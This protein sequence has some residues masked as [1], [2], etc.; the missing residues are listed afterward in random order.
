MN[1]DGDGQGDLA[2][3]GGEQRAVFVYQIESYRYWQE[4]LKRTDLTI[5]RTVRRELHDRRVA[6]RCGV[7]RRPL[8]DR[9]RAV[10]G[11]ATSRYLLSRRHSD[12]R[13]PN[14]GAADLQR[15]AG[16][17]LPRSRGRR[18]RRGRR[19]REGGRG[20]GADD[21]RRDQCA[22]LF[23]RIIRAICWSARCESRRFRRD[24]ARSFE[25]LL[26]SSTRKWK[27]R[28]RAGG[29]RA[30]GRAGISAAHGD[31]D[32]SGVRGRSLDDDAESGRSAAAGRAARASTWSCGFSPAAGAAADLSQLLALGSRLDRALS[33]QREDRAERRRREPGCG[34]MCASAMRSTSARLAAASFCKPESGRSCCSAP[35]SGRRRCWRCCTRWRRRGPRGRSCGSTRLAIGEHHP[36]AAEVRRLMLALAARPQLRLLQQAGLVGQAGRGFRRRR[37]FVA[38]GVRTGSASRATRTSTSAGRP[39]FMADM[40]DGA[41]GLWRRAGADSHRDLQRRRVDDSG[42]GRRGDARSASAR[43]ATPTPVRWCRSRAAASPRTGTRRPTRAF[44]SWPRRATFRSAGRAGPA[45]VTTARAVWFRGRWPTDR[46][47][48]T[49]RPK[50]TFSSAARSR[51]AISSSICKPNRSEERVVRQ[52]LRFTLNHQGKFAGVV[53]A[54]HRRFPIGDFLAGLYI[55]PAVG[56]MVDGMKNQSLMR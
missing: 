43:E 22:S 34:I 17:L 4:Q 48:S 26:Q 47:R 49:S 30:S 18:S 2:G 53:I 29:G 56:L 23:A 5:L 45:C 14:A 36:F 51:Q 1:L 31:V 24:G 19:D 37:S 35:E 54:P 39:R 6:R 46:S 10:R 41:R 38:I 28:S 16:I 32:R 7:H 40:K 15:T 9:Q 20:E 50:A 12:E 33:N 25:A 13:A 8:S 55:V 27:R 11:H 44:W 3:H 52:S 21:R 42:R